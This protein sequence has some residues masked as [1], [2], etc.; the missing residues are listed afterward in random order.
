MK[1]KEN[2]KETERKTH[3]LIYHLERLCCGWVVLGRWR[4]DHQPLHTPL[5]DIAMMLLSPTL[6]WSGL[7]CWWTDELTWL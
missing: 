1:V 3:T 7:V 2:K 5:V 6:L 4:L